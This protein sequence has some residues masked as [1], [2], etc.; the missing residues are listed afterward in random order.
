MQ[1]SKFKNFTSSDSKDDVNSIV[2][3]RL[4]IISGHL[5]KIIQMVEEDRYCIDILQ[6]SLA[7]KNA[8]KAV[9][10]LILER[11]LKRCVSQAVKGTPA[12]K[13]KSISEVLEIFQKARRG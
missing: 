3:R 6:Q 1:K 12:E 5:N 7:V 2:A 13:E 4:K 8:L 11:H 9:D 10:N